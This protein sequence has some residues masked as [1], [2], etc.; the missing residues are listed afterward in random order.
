MW[1]DAS[2]IAGIVPCPPTESLGSAKSCASAVPF[3]LS[4]A[5]QQRSLDLPDW[6]RST[7]SCGRTRRRIGCRCVFCVFS[8]P[9]S[10]KHTACK[11]DD[12]HSAIAAVIYQLRLHTAVEGSCDI[13][14]HVPE[15]GRGSTYWTG[16]DGCLGSQAMQSFTS[17]SKHS[18][19]TVWKAQQPKGCNAQQGYEGDDVRDNAVLGVGGS[20]ARC[21]ARQKL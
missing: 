10:S 9:M 15:K 16:R 6:L 5:E 7:Q 8:C 21:S 14:W 13:R 19:R 12:E 2:F 20:Y 11:A 4:T 1:Q 3:K 17:I 18:I